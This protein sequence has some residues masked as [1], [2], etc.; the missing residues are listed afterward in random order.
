[1]SCGVTA[2]TEWPSRRG[3][4]ARCAIAVT[5]PTGPHPRRASPTGV[6]GTGAGKP[7]EIV[8]AGGPPPS[9]AAAAA[10]SEAPPPVRQVVVTAAGELLQRTGAVVAGAGTTA[11]AAEAR[12]ASRNG[13]ESAM[14]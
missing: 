4:V 8:T 5:V 6:A 10:V 3:T 14:F 7:G 11:A 2:V 9:G 1:M 12:A 13:Q